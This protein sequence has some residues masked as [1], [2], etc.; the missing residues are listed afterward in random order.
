MPWK[1]KTVMEQRKEFIEQAAECSNFSELCREYGISRKTGYKWLKRFRETSSLED[2]SRRPKHPYR[3]TAPAVE[4]AILAMREENPSWGG[5][6]IRTVLEADGISNLPSAKT[7]CNILKKNGC[8]SEEESLKR[9]PCQR[10]ER[11]QCNALWQTDFKGD[12]PLLDGTRCYP[13]DILD[14]HSRFC[15]CTEPKS[16][17]AGVQE[18]FLR[19]FQAYGLPDAILSDNGPQFA[20]FRGGYTRFER[21]LM[22]LDILP[23]HGRILHP[24]TQ[25]KIERFHRTM[26]AEL[27]RE[28][29][30]DITEAA[31][32]FAAWRWK[33]N[34]IRPHS[35]LG[36][37]PPAKVYTP[38]KRQL[39]V[40]KPYEYTSGNV[41]KV[42]NW[43]YLRFGPVQLYLSETMANTYLEVVPADND[44]FSIR[45]RN[46]QIALVDANEK[47]LINRRIRKL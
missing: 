40:P 22:D 27:L 9:R 45:Y 5:K 10:F 3:K 44:T 35:A 14:D 2:Q 43:G 21:W 26:K 25:G 38:S 31:D 34:E 24:Q 39:F 28:P 1:E 23:I 33:Y 15:L 17:A 29:F 41:C 8:V 32:K 6:T 36:M 47:I 11:E 18:S 13:L 42:N 7:C 16:T 19:V 4:A 37:K 20:G 12:F 30:R 46:F